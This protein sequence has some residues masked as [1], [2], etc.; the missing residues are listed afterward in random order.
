MQAALS[1]SNSLSLTSSMRTSV[2]VRNTLERI[3]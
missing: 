2:E 1:H 3:I